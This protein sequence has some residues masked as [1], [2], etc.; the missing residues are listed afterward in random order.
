MTR[1]QHPS[2]SRCPLGNREVTQKTSALQRFVEYWFILVEARLW[3]SG[4]DRKKKASALHPEAAAGAVHPPG[5]K[6][7]L[8]FSLSSG[9][10]RRAG[11]E[12]AVIPAAEPQPAQA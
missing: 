3:R 11:R 7:F 8:L 6:A 10:W 5:T 1:E 12:I 2:A 9:R 4:E